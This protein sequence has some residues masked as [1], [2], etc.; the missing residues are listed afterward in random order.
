MT[1]TLWAGIIKFFWSAFFRDPL[2][3]YGSWCLVYV[4]VCGCHCFAYFLSLWGGG[5]VI[6]WKIA[7]YYPCSAYLIINSIMFYGSWCRVHVCVCVIVIVSHI[8]ILN[9]VLL[10]EARCYTVTVRKCNIPFFSVI[11]NIAPS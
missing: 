8:Q 10:S 3:F 4:C 9:F 5:G 1:C 7:V 11:V 6:L 2:M